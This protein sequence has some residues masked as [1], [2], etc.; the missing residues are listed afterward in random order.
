MKENVQINE[1]SL[2]IRPNTFSNETYY[3]THQTK[4]E[5]IKIKFNSNSKLENKI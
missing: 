2:Q 4:F 1:Q 3:V 5:D